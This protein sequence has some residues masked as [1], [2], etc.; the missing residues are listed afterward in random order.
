MYQGGTIYLGLEGRDHP[1]LVH[2]PLRWPNVSLDGYLTPGP[3]AREIAA[4]G[5]R[6]TAGT[7]RGSSRPSYFLKGYLFTQDSRG[8]A[9]AR[10]SDARSCSGC[11]TSSGTR[12]SSSRGTGRTSERRTALPVFYNA[13]I[14]QVPTP[15]DVRLLGM[16]VPHRPRG[17]RAAAPRLARSL[18]DDGYDAR[19]ARRLAAA[20]LGRRRPGGG[21]SSGRSGAAGRARARVR[22]G[23]PRR[24]SRATRGSRRRGG[25]RIA[26]RARDRDL[27]RGPARG[28]PHRRRHTDRCDRRRSATRGTVAGRRPSTARPAPVLPRRLPPAGRPGAGGR[29]RDPARVPR[30]G[31]RTRACRSRR[32][33]G[34]RSPACWA[35]AA[36]WPLGGQR[37]R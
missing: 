18:T 21:A 3:I 1:A 9:R 26:R 24:S 32:W 17:R 37:R 16:P 19:G 5:G 12:R 13:S 22:S 8:L 2:G 29:A 28:R 25:A 14:L 31:D 27:P 23:R 7:S 30:T 4:S 36:R 20:R 34:S 11:A 10:C 35:R 15:E 6:A 33:C